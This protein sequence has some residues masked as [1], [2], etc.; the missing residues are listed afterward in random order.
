MD[1]PSHDSA[2]YNEAL[3]G[4]IADDIANS[5]YSIRPNALPQ[6]LLEQLASY[7]QTIPIAD[8]K[9][10][11]VG[12]DGAHQ[13]NQLVRSDEICWIDGD[14]AA[15]A[16]WLEW[17]EALRVFLNRRLFLGL[18]SSESHFA[19]YGPGDYYQKHSDAFKGQANRL[20]SMVVYLNSEWRVEDGG[21]L[22]IYKA[23]ETR[24]SI[25]V[26]PSFG[27][28]VVFLSEDFPHEVLPARRDRFSIATWFRLNKAS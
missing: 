18:F 22:L 26:T 27:T 14:H 7:V 16:A 19:H 4:T 9:K 25:T 11:G 8:F 1:K 12:R 20:L 5:G 24:A 15:G 13:L 3:F 10:A 6:A 2:G 23:E 21:E 17:L 28:I